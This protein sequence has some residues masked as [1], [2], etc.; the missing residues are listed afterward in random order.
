MPEIFVSGQSI[1]RGELIGEMFR[2]YS[3]DSAG[4]ITVR[5]SCVSSFNTP[6]RFAEIN[7]I[8]TQ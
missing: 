1:G 7:E 2:P 6:Q 3:V 4:E 5:D 8:I